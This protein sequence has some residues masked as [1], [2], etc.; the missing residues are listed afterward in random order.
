M[1]TADAIPAVSSPTAPTITV[2]LFAGAAAEF[3]ADAASVHGTTLREALADLLRT[4]SPDSARVI[5]R[6]SL[7]VNAVACTDLDRPLSEGDR[8]DVL[9]PFA[10]G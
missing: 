4:A 7:L 3:G 5:G 9:P 1:T 2:R 10:G 6:S 8:L